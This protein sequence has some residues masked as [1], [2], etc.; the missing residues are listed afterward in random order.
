MIADSCELVRLVIRLFCVLTL[1]SP[2]KAADI[3]NMA[4]NSEDF[5]ERILWHSELRE[6]ISIAFHKLTAQ[7]NNMNVTQ[8]Q[9]GPQHDPSDQV[10]GTHTNVVQMRI[11][12]MVD[13]QD[14]WQS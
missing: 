3:E 8:P 7:G 9:A 4:F 6:R 13:W 11:E 5:L 10:G 2:I 12:L 1:L 14:S